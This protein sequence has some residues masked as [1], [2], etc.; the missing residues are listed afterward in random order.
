MWQCLQIV[1]LLTWKAEACTQ[2]TSLWETKDRLQRSEIADLISNVDIAREVCFDVAN[3][4]TSARVIAVIFC[5]SLAEISGV[6]D[7]LA[8]SHERNK[9]PLSA[10]ALVAT[11]AGI[12][13][14]GR[15]VAIVREDSAVQTAVPFK[16]S[17]MHRKKIRLWQAL[18]V[19]VAFSQANDSTLQ[20]DD[21]I[22][23]LK[24]PELASVKQYQE[25]GG[26]LEGHVLITCCSY[27]PTVADSFLF[28]LQL[29]AS[30][31]L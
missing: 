17:D 13:L 5:H 30:G 31:T 9:H 19:L 25:T 12:L 26:F 1:D 18:S 23:H 24:Q 4:A 21:V 20:V 14:L 22:D 27:N 28:P 7:N 16:G 2:M 10:Q 3:D 29:C 15:L 11:N 8:Q 6:A